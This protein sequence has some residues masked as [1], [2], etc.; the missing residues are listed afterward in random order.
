MVINKEKRLI[1]DFW[2]PEGENMNDEDH[3]ELALNFLFYYIM[4]GFTL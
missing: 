4:W 3:P 2:G 1:Y